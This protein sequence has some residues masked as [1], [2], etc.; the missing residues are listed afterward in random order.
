MRE[1]MARGRE[2]VEELRNRRYE[3]AEEGGGGEEEEGER[4][5]DAQETV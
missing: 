3:D 2:L 4:F 5:E 1:V